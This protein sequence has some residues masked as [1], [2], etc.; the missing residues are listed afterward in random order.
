MLRALVRASLSSPSKTIASWL[1]SVGVLAAGVVLYRSTLQGYFLADDFGYLQL[2]ARTPLAAFPGLFAADWSQG[3]W[4]RQL[5]ELR[6]LIGLTY[7]IE[8]RLWGTE[9]AGYHASNLIFHTLAAAGLYFFVLESGRGLTRSTSSSP[10]GDVSP[11]WHANAALGTLLFLLHPSH[12]EAV[13]WIAGRTDLLGAAAYFW[14][15]YCLARFWRQPS[16]A[17]GAA[18][19]AIF[20]AGLF[21][22]ENVITLPVAFGLYVVLTGDLR[23]R[24]RR[25]VPVALSLAGAAALWIVLRRLAFGATTAVTNMAEAVEGF[26]D[27]L[28]FYAEQITSIDSPLIAIAGIAVLLY[29]LSRWRDSGRMIAFWCFL[30]AVIHLAPLISV[31]YESSRHVM[32]AS[33]GLFVGLS[34]MATTWA[35][36]SR[37]VVACALALCL[38]CLVQFGLKTSSSLAAWDASFRHSRQLVQ[39]LRDGAYSSDAV[40]VVNSGPRVSTWFWQ[41]AL[42]FAAEPPFVDLEA[43]IVG[44][45]DWYC[46]EAEMQQR[47]AILAEVT[48]GEVS[49]VYWIDFYP[50]TNRFEAI[51]RKR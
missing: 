13:A 44:P 27:R 1:P 8:Y 47:D 36:R 23:A 45:P 28:S 35:G 16:V 24:W 37:V 40:V 25:F 3:I 51:I 29:G 12:V 22:K 48:A 17:L 19:I 7:W 38:F 9:P 4:G 39:L 43:R 33:A 6:P 49:E 2:Y 15:M 41:W 10:D 42:P 11:W 34:T 18:G 14:A 26:R 31:T 20:T 46:C 32:L 5:E 50:D 21:M 30:W